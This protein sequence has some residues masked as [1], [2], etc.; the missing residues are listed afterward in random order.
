MTSFGLIYL[1]LWSCG[2]SV[3]YIGF[4]TGMHG[5]LRMPHLCDKK[6]ESKEKT[7]ELEKL[8][9]KVIDMGPGNMTKEMENEL[10]SKMEEF[11]P[12]ELEIRMQIM[13]LNSWTLSG[14][15]F[16]CV[17]LLL[18]SI[19]GSGWAGDLLGLEMNPGIVI[20]RNQGDVRMRDSNFDNDKVSIQTIKLNLPENL[21]K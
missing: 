17:L 2:F 10:I 9:E 6:E 21:L 19:L 14:L 20:D 12:S 7:K 8:F 15:A 5:S 11:G 18:N 3:A 1:L 13:G 16:A 4:K